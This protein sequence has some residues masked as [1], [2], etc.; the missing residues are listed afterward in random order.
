VLL[1]VLLRHRRAAGDFMM[2]VCKTPPRRPHPLT[3]LL[4]A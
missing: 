4:S 1:Q 3:V 2:S